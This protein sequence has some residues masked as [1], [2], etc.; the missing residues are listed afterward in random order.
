[1]ILRRTVLFAGVVALIVA[2]VGLLVPV[3]VSPE[4]ATVGCGSAVAP[5]LSTAR[6]NDDRSAANMPILGEVVVDTNYTRLCQM[7][8]DDRRIWTITLAAAGF[9]AVVG[10]L[11]LGAL[12]NRRSRS[13]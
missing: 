2:V 9:L 10:A 11:A 5:D 7:D 6:A 12:S 1:M 8:L 4:G 13:P 3:S